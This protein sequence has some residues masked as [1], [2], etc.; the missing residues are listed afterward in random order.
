MYTYMY[1]YTETCI[2]T[3]KQEYSHSGRQTH[4]NTYR[5]THRCPYIDMHRST[6]WYTMYAQSRTQADRTQ[7]HAKPRAG[8]RLLQPHT[9]AFLSLNKHFKQTHLC[10]PTR[11]HKCTDIFCDTEYCVLGRFGVVSFSKHD[12]DK[13]R[14]LTPTISMHGFIKRTAASNLACSRGK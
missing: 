7:I 11:N 5:D 1:L 12:Q 14:E 4:M 3:Q 8:A 6:Q 9:A 13:Q 2:P 10:L